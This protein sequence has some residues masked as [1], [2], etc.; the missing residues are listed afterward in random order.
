MY[1]PSELGPAAPIQGCG[2][3]ASGFLQNRWIAAALALLSVLYWTQKNSF[4]DFFGNL[5]DRVTFRNPEMQPGYI[6][7][8]QNIEV[9]RNDNRRRAKR[10][11]KFFG[12]CIVALLRDF[13]KRGQ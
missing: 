2:E 12:C 9:L 13:E 1:I 5:A 3:S 8:L 6:Q 10:G 7:L 4:L 11:E